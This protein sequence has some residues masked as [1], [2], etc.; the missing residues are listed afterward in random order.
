M[1]ISLKRYFFILNLPRLHF[2]IIP[3]D[4][5]TTS[6]EKE[7]RDDGKNLDK[8]EQM[9]RWFPFDQDIVWPTITNH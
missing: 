9:S 7:K 2:E 8:R 1:L 4:N 5:V 3:H 6:L